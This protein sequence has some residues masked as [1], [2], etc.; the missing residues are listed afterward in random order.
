MSKPYDVESGDS[1]HKGHP[2]IVDRYTLGAR[3]N[4]WITAISLILLALSGMALF[5]PKLYFLTGLFGG[6]QWTRAIHPWIGVVL[7]FSFAGLFLRF[8]KAN[9]WK[10]EDGTWMRRIRDVLAGHEEKLPE[11]GKYNAGQKFVFWGMSAL[12]LVLIT[13]GFVVWD[14]YFY[15]FTSIPQKRVAILVHALAAIGIICIW[16]VH[17][18]AAIW[19][20]GTIGA[21]T[22]GQVTGGWAWRHHR[23]WL[24]E[25]VGPRSRTPA[26]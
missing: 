3:I 24:R 7:F 26:E 25:L 1:V 8:W 12:I 11:L 23:K 17:V 20:R 19:V 21:M 5:S 2:V 16:I 15:E 13:S 4:H 10:S 9:L 14:Q 22:K 6:G 18:Y